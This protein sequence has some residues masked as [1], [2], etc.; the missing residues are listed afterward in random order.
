[1]AQRELA[2]MAK[3][4]RDYGRATELW[5]QLARSR[6]A[7]SPEVA[8]EAYEQ[9][10]IYYEHK[11]RDPHRA[12][13]LTQAAI[14]ELIAVSTAKHAAHL[15]CAQ[16]VRIQTRLER[17]LARLTRNANPARAADVTQPRRGGTT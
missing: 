6:S 10:A 13:E 3:R 15:D 9:L 4:Q 17:R 11:A 14:Q 1:M 5:Q 2:Q 16:S 7:K 8:I 12:A